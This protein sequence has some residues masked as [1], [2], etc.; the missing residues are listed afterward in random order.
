MA[1]QFSNLA[2]TTLASGVSSSATSVSVTSASLFPSLGGSDY[3]YATLGEDAGSEIVKVTAISG[4]TFTVVRAQDGTSAISH[5]AGTHFALRVTAAALEDL[6]DSPNVES[7]SKSGDTMTGALLGTTASFS[8]SVTAASVVVSGTVDGRDVATDGTKLDGVEASATADQTGAQIKTAYQA[9][10]N[11]FT[12]AQFTKLGGIEA[13]ATVTNTAS[14]TAAGALMDSEL[15][16]IASVKALNQGVS[17]GNS[18]TFVNVTATSL[19]ISGNI[20]V[21]G[22]T[23]LDVVDIDG[24]VDMASTLTVAGGAT[25]GGNSRVNGDFSVSAASGEDRFAI[26]PQSAGT[27]TIIFSGNEGLS[28]YEP[29]VIDFETLALR[30][31]GTPRLSIAGNGAAT[32]SSTVTSTGLT[33]NG[34]GSLSGNLRVGS[35]SSSGKLTVGTFG[36]TA[37]AAQFHG[38]SI[39]IDGGAASEIIIGDGNVAYMSIQTTDDA[40]AMKIRNFSGNA[41]L[42]TI[43]RA[44]GNVGIG[45]SPVSWSTGMRALELKGYSGATKQ[46]S[47][48]FVSHSGSNGYN[49]ISTD[50]GNMVFYNGATNRASAVETMRITSG[51]AVQTGFPATGVQSIAKLSSKYNGAA[52]EFGHGNNSAGYYGTLGAFGSNGQ[53]YIGFSCDSQYNSNFFTT[54]GHRGNIIAGDL[55]GNL[56]FL[57]VTSASATNQTAVERMRIDSSG[58][59]LVGKTAASFGTAGVAVFGSGEIDITNTNEAPLFLNR[60]GS[61]GVIQYFYKSG[62]AVGSISTYGGLIQIGQGNANLKFSNAADAI[63]PAN[64]SGSNNDNAVDLGATAARFKDLYLAGGV[65]F[66]ANANAGGMTSEL[67]DDYEEGTW[68]P[69]IKAIGTGGNN[70]TYT[71]ANPGATYTKV[72][73]LVTVHT[74]IS[75]ININA[76]TGG[77]YITLHGFPFQATNYADFTIA[78]KSGNWSTSGNIIGGY[79]QS[80]A[81]YVFFMRANGAEAQQGSTDV[82]LTHAMINITYQAA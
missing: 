53:P 49:L 56:Q 26:L 10:T 67:L 68:T 31:S 65:N 22:V 54:R 11:A 41:D 79:V 30:T 52:I 66:S 80:G 58:N 9:E 69:V 18:P 4:T 24:A 39:L 13:L 62:T 46:G 5:N 75:G 32:F 6:R 25:F 3:F 17:T 70:A 16:S 82:T 15:T 63:T 40:T 27:G 23:N 48:A 8:G 45:S 14:V 1:I 33:V 78:Y 47:I 76:I 37:R 34:G 19:D 28:A 51:G 72:G 61:D 64:G 35:S 71:I 7:V 60:L 38:G 57:Q 43:E 44:T 2:S 77:T 59:L 74:Y 29:L 42:V 81:S 20:D 21:D 50:T 55:S 73:R 12:D 36:D